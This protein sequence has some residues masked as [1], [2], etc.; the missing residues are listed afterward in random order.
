MPHESMVCTDMRTEEEV[1]KALEG[2][3]DLKLI[4]S[5]GKWKMQI[6]LLLW[7][8]GGN[9]EEL[10]AMP[11]EQLEAAGKLYLRKGRLP[12]TTEEE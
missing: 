10:Q 3:I 5:P 8:L 12:G 6:R 2:L 11:Y 4:P 9:F 7:T 1:K